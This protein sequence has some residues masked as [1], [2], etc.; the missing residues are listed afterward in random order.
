MSNYLKGKTVYLC[1][2][3]HAVSDDGKGWREIITPRLKRIGINVLNPCK[4]TSHDSIDEVGEDKKIF[5]N[6]IEQERWEELKEKFW[7]I[8]RSDLRAIDMADFVIFNYDPSVPM[9]GS[10]HEMVVAQF[11]KK[12]VLLKY[13]KSQLPDFNPWICTFVKS[14]HFFPEWEKMYD[15][16]EKVN[17]GIFDTSLWVI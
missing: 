10:I 4:K 8:V 17:K 1:G 2:P 16:L 15:Y 3:I 6:L 5:R 12:V 13:Q 14:H 11:E 7:K 9:C